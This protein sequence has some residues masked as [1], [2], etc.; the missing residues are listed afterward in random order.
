MIIYKGVPSNK[1]TGRKDGSSVNCPVYYCLPLQP[2]TA[3]LNECHFLERT[4]TARNK[5]NPH[6]RCVMLS[7]SVKL[8][9]VW[10]GAFKGYHTKKKYTSSMVPEVLTYCPFK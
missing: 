10:T 5:A 8:V 9:C 7:L 4:P 1:V 6:R 3:H 2:P